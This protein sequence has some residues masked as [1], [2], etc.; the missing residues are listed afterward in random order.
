MICRRL[1]DA[2]PAAIVRVGALY[3]PPVSL[4]ESLAA[5]LKL[6]KTDKLPH[7]DESY[8]VR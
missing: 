4:A 5:L 3:E 1:F 7:N 2:K 8:I 6:V